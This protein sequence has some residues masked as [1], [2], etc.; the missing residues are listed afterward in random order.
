MELVHG[1]CDAAASV[2]LAELGDARATEPLRGQLRAEVAAAL[3]RV[4]HPRDEVVEDG[5]RRG[6]WAG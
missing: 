5:R 1:C 2:P 3:L 6:G 4:P